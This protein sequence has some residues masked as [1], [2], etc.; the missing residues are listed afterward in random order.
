MCLWSPV[1]SSFQL[2][3]INESQA[4][5]TDARNKAE[6]CE[7]GQR[8]ANQIW[9]S[10]TVKCSRGAVVLVVVGR[11]GYSVES[12]VVAVYQRESSY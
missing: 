1:S 4:R 2:I 10:G 5:R 3:A 7:T 6:Q 9:L 11:L 12:S 8:I